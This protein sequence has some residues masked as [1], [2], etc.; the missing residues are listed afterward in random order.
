M[1]ILGKLAF[2]RHEDAA[3]PKVTPPI[4]QPGTF[5]GE[6]GKGNYPGEYDNLGLPRQE[7]SQ[8]AMQGFPE[9]P[10]FAGRM[11]MPRLEEAQRQQYEQY[12]PTQRK[13]LPPFQQMPQQFQQE[14]NEKDFEIISLKLDNLKSALE[15]I[16]ER[17]GRIE[18]LAEGEE[19]LRRY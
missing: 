5:P 1:S 10:S 16:N 6:Y 3:L 9:T 2:W 13:P 4:S 17:L 19:R 8:Q 18:K 15:S 12:G 7:S 11:E 14:G